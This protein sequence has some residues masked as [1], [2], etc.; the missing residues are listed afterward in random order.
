MK[1]D[2][3]RRLTK[4]EQR[5]Q[6]NAEMPPFIIGLPTLTPERRQ[7]LATGERIVFDWLRNDNLFVEAV[8]RITTDPHDMGRDCPNN[9]VNEDLI[10]QYHAQC[11]HREKG[12]CRMCEGL[13]LFDNQPESELAEPVDTAER[14]TP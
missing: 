4:L 8:E 1:R 11:G 12:E 9:T 2:L 14:R 6:A 13:G 10:R 5:Y 7:Q 3:L